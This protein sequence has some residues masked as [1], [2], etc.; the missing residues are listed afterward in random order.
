M[1]Y[2]LSFIGKLEEHPLVIATTSTLLILL[3]GFITAK[4][5]GLIIKKAFHQLDL[6]RNLS[7]T[8][9]KKLSL[10]KWVRG[11]V[12]VTVYAVAIIIALVNLGIL[13]YAFLIIGG[14][15][16]A[17]LLVSTLLSLKDAGPNLLAGISKEYRDH[18]TIGKKMTVRTVTGV[19]I[20]RGLFATTIKEGEDF[21]LVPNRT[22]RR[23]LAKNKKKKTGALKKRT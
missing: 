2:L 11:L 20:K 3:A 12:T 19:V 15:F 5:L 18:V 13:N 14:V 22:M 16:L 1:I 8:I 4:L 17:I 7:T 6:D 10:E 9:G 21:L 23:A